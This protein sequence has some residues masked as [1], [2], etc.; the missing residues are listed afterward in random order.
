MLR[1]MATERAELETYARELR[2]ILDQVCVSLA[3]LTV[4]QQNWRPATPAPNSAYAVAAHVE[5]STRV[6]ALGFG[7]GHPVHRDR[8]SE[9]IGSGIDPKEMIDRLRQLGREIGAAL[10]ALAPGAL[11]ERV[12][13]PKELWGTGDPREISRRDALV[14]SIRHAA[15]HLGELRLTRDLAIPHA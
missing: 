13:P 4:A 3:G 11:D 14:E 10:A 9:F 7:C 5:A 12:L 2:W 8:D 15:I 1:L 6:Y